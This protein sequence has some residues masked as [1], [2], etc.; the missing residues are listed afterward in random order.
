MFI[1]IDIGLADIPAVTNQI[2]TAFGFKDEEIMKVIIIVV[3]KILKLVKDHHTIGNYYASQIFSA[4][5]KWFPIHIFFFSCGIWFKFF[6]V[7]VGHGL[8]SFM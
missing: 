8:N 5:K 6:Y 2:E 3:N 7:G 1:K 4:P